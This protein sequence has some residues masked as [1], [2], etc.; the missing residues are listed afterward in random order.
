MERRAILD[1]LERAAGNQ[2]LAARELGMTEQALRY[3]LKKYGHTGHRQFQR[4]RS[5]QRRPRN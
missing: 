2:S 3:R 1:A 5:I 4:T